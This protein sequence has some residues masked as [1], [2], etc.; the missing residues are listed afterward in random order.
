MFELAEF[1][2]WLAMIILFAIIGP[3]TRIASRESRYWS[4]TGARKILRDQEVQR[5]ESAL[6]ERDQVIED[7]QR[8]VSEMEER[9]DFTERL[10]ATRSGDAAEHTTR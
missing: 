9:L 1:P 7:L 2:W 3:V 10:L 4:R 6:G 5:L 8:R